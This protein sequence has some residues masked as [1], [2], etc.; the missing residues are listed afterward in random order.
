VVEAL[1]APLDVI[2]VRKLGVPWQPQL[3]FGAIGEDGVRVLNPEVA[4]RIAP[5]DAERV[6]REERAK[7]DRR[8]R[9]LR[10]GAPADA[11]DRPDRGAARRKGRHRSDARAGCPVARALLAT[12]EGPHADSFAIRIPKQPKHSQTGRSGAHFRPALFTAK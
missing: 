11:A 12:V 3:A 7:L 8:V 6:E 10:G 1:R 9:L 5:A 4:S 2:V